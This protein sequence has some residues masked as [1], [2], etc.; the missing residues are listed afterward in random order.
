MFK[1]IVSMVPRMGET[2]A[3][4]K[5]KTLSLDELYSIAGELGTVEMGGLFGSASVDIKV[6]FVG[7]DYVSIRERKSNDVKTN[8][9]RCI[10]RSVELREIYKA[11]GWL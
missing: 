10:H 7:D 11:Q 8:L 1:S 5:L 3:E 6:N 2:E 4:K 9:A